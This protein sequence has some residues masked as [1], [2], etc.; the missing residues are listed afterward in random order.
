MV[1]SGILSSIPMWFMK[2]AKAAKMPVI[3]ECR[4][5]FVR[6]LFLSIILSNLSDVDISDDE[7]GSFDEP[8]FSSTS[9]RS[10]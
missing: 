2:N 6:L 8:H 7:R 1:F 5:M 10:G 3:R 9:I 4:L